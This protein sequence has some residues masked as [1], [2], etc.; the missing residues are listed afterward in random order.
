MTL[1]SPFFSGTVAQTRVFSL[2][3]AQVDIS[4]TVD[5]IHSSKFLLFPEHG[6]DARSLNFGFPCLTPSDGPH[7]NLPKID[8]D[9]NPTGSHY[10]PQAH[11]RWSSC[12]LMG[13]R[14]VLDLKSQRDSQLQRENEPITTFINS[15]LHC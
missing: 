2:P 6:P 15:V 7:F 8:T 3:R 11:R 1:Q 9:S 10:G 12:S 13:K 4:Q 14:L 5:I